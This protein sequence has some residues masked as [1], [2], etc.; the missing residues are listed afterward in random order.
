MML[1]SQGNL[2]YLD[3]EWKYPW[4]GADCAI[5]KPLESLLRQCANE[6]RGFTIR[7]LPANFGH[8]LADG[9]AQ[10][11]KLEEFTLSSLPESD[12]GINERSAIRH[13]TDAAPNLRK[14]FAKDPES[15]DLVPEDKLRL[16]DTL[17]FHFRGIQDRGLY[18][19]VAEARSALRKLRIFQ[20]FQCHGQVDNFQPAFNT[21]LKKLFAACHQTLEIISIETVYPIS[22]L[23]CPPLQNSRKLK[24]KTT[25]GPL[26]AFSKTLVVIDYG[27]TMPGLEEVV[28]KMADFVDMDSTSGEYFSGNKAWPSVDEEIMIKGDRLGCSHSVRKLTLDL[29]VKT[30]NMPVLKNLFPDLSSM[31]IKAKHSVR[32][33]RDSLPLVEIFQLWPNLEGL[34]I[35]GANNFLRRSYDADLCGIHEGE[36]DHLRTMETRFLERVQIVPIRPSLL[37]MPSK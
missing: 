28:I 25:F 4:L 8:L 26:Q 16:L 34:K 10:F 19:K 14:I 11:P 3:F 9:A 23:S 13:I 21:A 7:R 12:F 33:K 20:R 27:R 15:L 32:L 6:L 22:W 30:I 29:H 17:T 1:G 36:A 31:E 18:T 5:H 2:K 35:A 24:L 37:T